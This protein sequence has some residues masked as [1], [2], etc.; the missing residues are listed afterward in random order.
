MENLRQYP[1]LGKFE[2]ELLVAEALYS[3]SLDGGGD[4]EAGDVDITGH[5][6]LLRG[7]FDQE[8]TNRLQ[9]EFDLN[10]D[11]VKF[12]RSL[13][14]AILREGSQGF[15][16]AQYFTEAD[17]LEEA[18]DEVLTECQKENSLDDEDQE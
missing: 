10:N 6:T 9:G 2:G 11:E 14:G 1:H 12:L 18:W 16:S 8:T 3:L 4:E 7:P 17:K 5:Y 15:V 13:A